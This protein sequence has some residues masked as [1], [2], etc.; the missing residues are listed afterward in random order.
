MDFPLW[1]IFP[2]IFIVVFFL[3]I[4]LEALFPK[5]MK[6][7]IKA[8]REIYGIPNRDDDETYV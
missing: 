4:I 5:C 3:R 6:E 8:G 1:F 2:A 7:F